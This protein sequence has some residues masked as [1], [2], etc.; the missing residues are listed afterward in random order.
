MKT[1]IDIRH[2]SEVSMP[3][4]IQ[5]DI[6]EKGF[7]LYKWLNPEDVKASVQNSFLHAFNWI[8]FIGLLIFSIF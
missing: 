5:H 7:H 3:N 2:P 8:W 4:N 1:L 6:D